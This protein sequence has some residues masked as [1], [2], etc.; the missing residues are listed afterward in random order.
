MGRELNRL[1]IRQRGL[2]AKIRQWVEEDGLDD[3][4]WQKGWKD[5]EMF[6]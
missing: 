5:I 3:D 2:K 4:V 1:E 6:E